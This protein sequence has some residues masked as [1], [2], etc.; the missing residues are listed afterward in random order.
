MHADT[1]ETKQN[2]NNTD[3]PVDRT[4]W[5]GGDTMGQR[6]RGDHSEQNTRVLAIGKGNAATCLGGNGGTQ[7]GVVA[8]SRN[9]TGK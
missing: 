8:V 3:P 7:S 9:G 6:V 4:G 5:G 2:K 1:D